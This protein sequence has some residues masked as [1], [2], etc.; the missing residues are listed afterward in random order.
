MAAYAVQTNVLKPVLRQAVVSDAGII[1]RVHTESWR[2]S[3]RGMLSDDYLDG[4]IVEERQPYWQKTLNAPQPERRHVLV[5][6]KDKVLIA[7]VS[8]FL[9][10]EPQYG[11]LLHNLHVLPTWKGQ[12]VGRLLVS[13]AARWTL[14]QDV[15]QMHL[16][17]F[18]VNHEARKFYDALE[19]KIVEEKL[20]TVAG[21]V[22]RNLLCYLWTDL[23]FLANLKEK[24]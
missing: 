1:A 2:S 17:V 24:R 3:Y 8:V 19:G 22:E 7:F 15:K 13:E 14:L 18:K 11:A 21:N 4:G 5:A 16:W 6:E 10:E 9:D 23:N 20:Q 12:G